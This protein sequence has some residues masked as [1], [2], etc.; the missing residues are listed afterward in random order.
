VGKERKK[1]GGG[2]CTLKAGGQG[3]EPFKQVEEDPSGKGW[4]CRNDP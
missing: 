3:K 1:A 4:R 2:G